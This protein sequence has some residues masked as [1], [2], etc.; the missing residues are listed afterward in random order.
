MLP[1]SRPS[2][3]ATADDHPRGLAKRQSN[4]RARRRGLDRLRHEA[5][6]IF[7]GEAR[8]V[9]HSP[10]GLSTYP[11]GACFAASSGEMDGT[12]TS[13]L[14]NEPAGRAVAGPGAHEARRSEMQR[15]EKR[16]ANAVDE[17][18]PGCR[19]AHL[20]NRI[21]RRPWPR[22]RL[23]Q[24]LRGHVTRR[25]TPIPPMTCPPRRRGMP[26]GFTPSSVE[27][28]GP[29]SRRLAFP[30]VIPT[31]GS[32]SS[33]WPNNRATRRAPAG[34]G[35]PARQREDSGLEENVPR[36]DLGRSMGELK[37]A[38]PRSSTWHP[39]FVFSMPYSAA[40]PVL[41]I[42]GGNESR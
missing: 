39:R 7:E 26:P 19:A 13:P 41:G 38:S 29:S 14:S 21:R 37:M 27:P 17:D 11:S 22:L 36:K 10:W 2:P 23:T 40:G 33:G 30:V 12:R 5:L 35:G 1:G 16:Q 20:G 18:G 24:I 15:L 25:Q 28:S 31:E 34:I 32:G 4:D 3:S 42:P 9:V 6:N 8:R